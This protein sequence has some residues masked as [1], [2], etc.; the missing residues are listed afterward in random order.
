MLNIGDNMGRK[1]DL[2]PVCYLEEDKQ[3][4]I[5]TCPV[6]NLHKED[7]SPDVKYED[8]FSNDVKKSGH[9]LKEI[10]KSIRIREVILSK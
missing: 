9:I 4:H 3:S 6:I 2:C 1:A 10:K 5:L 8:I 7:I